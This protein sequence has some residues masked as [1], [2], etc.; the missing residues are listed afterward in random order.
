[1]SAH[2]DA[3]TWLGPLSE[4]KNK[5]RAELEKAMIVNPS[6]GWMECPPTDASV[7]ALTN[8]V[9][10]LHESV[11]PAFMRWWR[12]GVVD[13]TFVVCGHS[14]RT[15]KTHLVLRNAISAFTWLDGLVREPELASR[16]VEQAGRRPS[17]RI[18]V[19]P[20]H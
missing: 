13:D 14:A 8:D 1:M 3:E 15:L 19:E 11:R 12:E 4:V 16:M 18:V 7:E 5:I 17:W 9:L 6:G 2:E 20:L 10:T